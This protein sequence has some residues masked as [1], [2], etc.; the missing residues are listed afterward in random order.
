[1]DTDLHRLRE[2]AQ[3]NEDPKS[4]KT[5]MDTDQL[6]EYAQ[7]IKDAK[8]GKTKTQL[9]IFYNEANFTEL[10]GDDDCIKRT[11]RYTANTKP[12]LSL[13]G[14]ILKHGETL[15]IKL[16]ILP[17]TTETVRSKVMWS[18]NIYNRDTD[19]F[20]HLGTAEIS[21]SS[22]K[23]ASEI[24]IQSKIM[25]KYVHEHF[26]DLLFKWNVEVTCLF[27]TE[28]NVQHSASDDIVGC[29]VPIGNTLDEVMKFLS[30]EKQ[31]EGETK[32][33]LQSILA[34]IGDCRKKQTNN[35]DRLQTIE[36]FLF[37]INYRLSELLQ[38]QDKKQK[39][40]FC[41]INK[42]ASHHGHVKVGQPQ[43]KNILFIG[44][45]V[46][47]IRAFVWQKFRKETFGQNSALNKLQRIV[48]ESEGIDLYVGG[49]SGSSCRQEILDLMTF[50]KYF[51]QE[52][53][54]GCIIVVSS[55]ADINIVNMFDDTFLKRKCFLL[56]LDESQYDCLCGR[57]KEII[58]FHWCRPTFDLLQNSFHHL[59]AKKF[60]FAE[61]IVSPLFHD[62][63]QY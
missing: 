10:F 9:D 52:D 42:K 18:F 51:T 53:F 50:C 39:E 55:A 28:S 7:L 24:D 23:C 61:G 12:A 34:D 26:V 43:N 37:D 8:R 22:Q 58:Y 16:E 2:Y 29:E 6:H 25:K 57:V 38:K 11:P 15:T 14:V 17:L 27:L 41:Q 49:V 47:F 36:R 19:N 60:I 13:R 4:G 45:D 21:I 54:H 62:L 46:Q 20:E 5:A 48:W 30:C 35:E 3:R 32:M 40:D 44:S 59:Q 1:M 33:T 31:N 63:K 56:L